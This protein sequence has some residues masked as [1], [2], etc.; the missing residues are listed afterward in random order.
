MTTR[1]LALTNVVRQSTRERSDRKGCTRRL[2]RW[3][4]PSRQASGGG[5]FGPKRRRS[6]SAPGRAIG[7]LG[8]RDRQSR[9]HTSSRGRMSGL[10]RIAP[11]R[12]SGRMWVYKNGDGRLGTQA[13]MPLDLSDRVGQRPSLDHE[14]VNA[15]PR[16]R[17]IHA[18]VTVNQN[19]PRLVGR[20]QSRSSGRRTP[21][22]R[23][24]R[25]TGCRDT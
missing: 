16:R 15:H 7:H 4:R 12:A 11:E 13:A 6:G 1:R 18:G 19:R 8:R 25:A 10:P 14:A 17:A 22:R 9:R 21:R 23:C 24:R 5:P 20:G 2:R 3:S